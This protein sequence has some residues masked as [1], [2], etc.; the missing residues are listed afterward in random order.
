[1][2]LNRRR[3][4]ADLLSICVLW[5]NTSTNLY[6]QIRNEGLITIPSIRYIKKL[7]S[8]LTVD[9]GLTDQTI[10]YLE[11]RIA[12]LNEREKIGSL[13]FDEVCVA[14]RCEFSRSTGQIYGMENNQPTKTLLTVMFKSIASK[15]EDVIAMV[16]LT[17][18]NS[19]TLLNLFTSVMTAITSIGYDVVVSLVDGHSSNVKFYKEELCGNTFTSYIPHP[20]DE[21]LFFYLLF[22]ATHIFKCIYNNFQRKV[23]F[24]C[25]NFGD[26]VVSANFHHLVEL[27]N[28]E[29]GKPVKMAYELTDEWLNPQPIEKTRVSLAVRVFSEST[30]NAMAYFLKNGHPE[31]E[32][33]LNFLNLIAKWCSLLN[34]KSTSKGVRKRDEDS[35]P[36]TLGNLSKLEFLN[37]FSTWLHEWEA[38]G[39][40]GLS[41]ETF[42]SCRQT[43]KTFPLLVKYL[44]EEKG[45]KYVLSGN[46][47][48]DP[49]EKRFGRYRQTSGANYFAR[50]KQF[51]EAE[52]SIR[53]QSLIK[54]SGYTMK[55]ACEVLG[56]NDAKIE[57]EVEFH[58][59]T[60]SEVMLPKMKTV[61]MEDMDRDIV[62]YV[63]GFISRSV[64]KAIKCIGCG[65]M[66]GNSSEIVINVG[67]VVPQNCQSF[68]DMINRRGLVKPSDIVYVVCTVAWDVYVRIMESCEAKLYFLASKMQRKVFVNLVVAEITDN[69]DYGGIL[70]TSC[71]KNHAFS[72]MLDKL[73]VK[74]FNVMC[75][76]F[77]SEINSAVHKSKK[78]SK[79]NEKN[80]G[81]TY[82]VQT[83]KVRKLNSEK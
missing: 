35:V 65:D 78:R 32:G 44:L 52:K 64:K 80:N 11:A 56:K 36:I 13:I 1:M 75:K 76:N 63:A 22:D 46:M 15:Y 5:E 3:Y 9:T 57:A 16:P 40:T 53:V 77:V 33:T 61:S 17:T 82:T 42:S 83:A 31:W 7:T 66:L 55:E 62:Y 21:K 67:G 71:I 26:C 72:V 43:S 74:F 28:L 19:S 79:R 73:V 27:Y 58:S 6:K 4:S 38:S 49:L 20:V 8:A 54:F 70:E 34:V 23:V 25:P 48:S 68:V 81:S 60:L 14:K 2:H 10:K 37:K 41:R 12:K 30:R 47:Q 18:I 69:D 51:L 59:E 39:K 24:E 29:L 45:L 50:E